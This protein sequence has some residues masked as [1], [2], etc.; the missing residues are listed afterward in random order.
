M[1]QSVPGMNVAP[2]IGR[3]LIAIFFIPSGFS[4]I[5]GFSGTVGYIA[6]GGLPAPSLGAVI[7]IIVEVVVAA[8][9]LVG[10]QARWSALILAAFTI[11]AALVFHNYWAAPADQQMM[12]QINFFKNIA[13]AGGLLFVYAFGPGAYSLDA[14]SRRAHGDVRTA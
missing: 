3:I 14:R 5:T 2:L 7:A 4:K 13:I 1:A 11:A 8:S 10:W 12:Q 9:L 6:S